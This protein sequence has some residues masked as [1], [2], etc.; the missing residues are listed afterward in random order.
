MLPKIQNS[1]T[2]SGKGRTVVFD[3]GKMNKST[4]KSFEKLAKVPAT[5][6]KVKAVSSPKKYIEKTLKKTQQS[7]SSI[8][9]ISAFFDFLQKENSTY[10]EQ[11]EDMEKN[12]N[13]LRQNRHKE[14]MDVLISA[15]KKKTVA[16]KKIKKEVKKKV[17]EPKIKPTETTKPATQPTA[18]AA[19]APKPTTQPARPVTEAPKPATQPVQPKVETAKPVTTPAAPPPTAAPA[20]AAPAAPKLSTA[21]PAITTKAAKTAVKVGVAT[22][23]AV[24]AGSALS[25]IKGHEKFVAKAYPDPE[26]NP[27]GSIKKMYYSVGYGHQIT[28]QEIKQGYIKIGDTKVSVVGDLGKDTI[29]TKEQGDALVAQDFKKYEDAAKAIPNFD[30]LNQDAKD[31]LIDITY[32]MGVGW[33]KKFPSFM[34]SMQNMDFEKAADELLYVDSTK[35]KKT[36]YFTQVKSRAEENANKIRKGLNLS[37]QPIQ[38]SNIGDKINTTTLDNNDMKK[39]MSRSSGGQTILQMNNNTTTNKIVQ[40]PEKEKRELNP[41]MQ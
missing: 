7:L 1:N 2:V 13:E 19:E 20:P 38:T 3:A 41:T 33:T 21:A 14:I 24:V 18:P 6:T 31:A 16:E 27:D 29:L 28:E 40:L 36:A 5:E 32:N 9:S 39:S 12:D 4:S 35:T 26:K 37:D 8:T 17:E 15:T 25:K 22:G 23:A 11:M 30:K 34:K 10:H